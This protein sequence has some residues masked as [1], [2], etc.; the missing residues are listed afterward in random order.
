MVL[1]TLLAVG[2]LSLSTVHLRT[3]SQQLAHAQARANARLALMIAIGE[4]QKQ[5]GPDQRVSASGAILAKAK[6][7]HPRWTGVWDS[8]Q[9]GAK[10]AGTASPDKPSEHQTIKGASNSGMS[11]T[12]VP[13]REDHFRSW[14]VSLAPEEAKKISSAQALALTGATLP[15]EGA[16]AVK[17]VGTGSLGPEGALDHVRWRKEINFTNNIICM[18]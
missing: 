8:W 2:L 12:Y 3:A 9:A 6:V 18:V 17:L 15:G 5:L 16:E 4:L 7:C 11:P 10:V 13:Q 14:L 1:L